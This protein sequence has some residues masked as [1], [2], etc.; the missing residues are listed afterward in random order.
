MERRW[1]DIKPYYN[2]SVRFTTF[3]AARYLRRDTPMVRLTKGRRGTPCCRAT[4]PKNLGYGEIK[5]RGLG[6]RHKA[7]QG[8]RY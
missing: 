5:G 2:T 4:R 7:D 8:E 3:P 1:R 6:S